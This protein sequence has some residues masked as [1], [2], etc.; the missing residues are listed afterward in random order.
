MP[1]STAVRNVAVVGH[2]GAGKT[3]LVEALLH[4]AGAIGRAGDVQDGT[5]TCDHEDVERRL[6]HSVLLGVTAL[7]HDGVV[8]N[9]LDTPGSPELVGALR[10]G[11]RAADAVL[12]VV[13]GVG[14]L[15]P[16]TAQ[17]WAECEAA[18]VPRAVAVTQLDRARADVDEAIAL[19]QRLL[20]ED[21]LPVSLPM[22]DDDGAVAGLLSLL[23][24]RLVDHSS[25]ARVVRAAEPEHLALVADLR[26]DLVETVLA[27][28]DDDTL[29]DRYLD[30]DD[31][32]AEVL[33][34]E[35]EAGVGRGDLWPAL[36]VAPLLGVGLQELLDLLTRAFPPPDQVEPLPA[37]RPDGTPVEPLPADPHG[38]LLAEV[39]RVAVPGAYVR[40]RSGTLR[41]GDAVDLAGRGATVEAL[42]HALG[43]DLRPLDA[44]PAGDV[45]LVA[46]LASAATG[47]T[48]SSPDQ[49]LLLAPWRL[50]QPQHAV[51]LEPAPDVEGALQEL[52]AQDPTVQVESRASTRQLLLWCLGPLHAE[53]LLDRLQAQ[54][55]RPVATAEVAVPVEHAPDGTRLQPWWEV[56]VD[57]PEP[58]GR[59]V[60]SDLSGRRA[61]GATL[62]A[63]EDDDGRVVVR[64]E[65]PEDELL[66]YAVALG[67]LTYGTG[68]FTRRPL[69]SRPAPR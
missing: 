22:H 4:A 38:P 36:P 59:T 45:C 33:V 12:F 64:A 47:D 8:V 67:A 30:D 41:V 29:L 69:G 40:V 60:R 18:G 21:V 2:R 7:E 15:D 39:V 42:A 32:D 25:G 26:G 35:L 14:G 5:T 13:S 1:S 63:R 23:D 68:S 56:E 66:G 52:V 50:P 6:G 48:L 62:V 46:G 9:L 43:A 54:L 17:L 31:V 27:Q 53:V 34:R 3:T 44:C 16:A 51:A 37:S 58:F 57:V 61:T 55:G 28:S 10:A 19:C 49:P 11:L 24:L 65:L 20:S